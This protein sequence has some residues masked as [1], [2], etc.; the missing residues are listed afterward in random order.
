MRNIQ[1]PELV[2][3][4]GSGNLKQ[5]KAESK[6][7]MDLKEEPKGDFLRFQGWR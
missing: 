5:Q 3:Q 4:K 1:V 7:V 6:G 2:K